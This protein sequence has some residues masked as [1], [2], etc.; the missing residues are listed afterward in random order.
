M[1]LQGDSKLVLK[2]IKSNSI[3][4]IATDPPYGIKFMGK[5]WDVDLPDIEIWEECYRV[6]KPG[7]FI[8][9]M[10]STRMDDLLSVDLRKSGF[11]KMDSIGWCYGCLSED[12]EILTDKGWVRYHKTIENDNVL[13]YN[14]NGDKYEWHKPTEKISY[15]HADTAYRIEGRYTDQLVSPDHR[16]AINKSGKVVF[17]EA[18]TCVWQTA[19]MVVLPRLWNFVFNTAS[20]VKTNKN[21]NLLQ[22]MQR[23]LSW[24]GTDKA[25]SQRACGL[26]RKIKSKLFKKND[27]QKQSSL[28]GWRNIF[29]EKRLLWRGQVNQVCKMPKRIYSDVAKR[30]VCN[31]ISVVSSDSSW[32]SFGKTGMRTS[33]RPQSSQQRVDKFNVI[34]NKQRP[35]TIRTSRR[36]ATDLARITPVYYKGL[37]W[38]IEVP[39]GAFVA[40]RNGKAFITGNSGFPKGTDLSKQLDK[41]TIRE[42]LDQH[43]HGLDA[44]QIRKVISAGINGE[45]FIPFVATE[46]RTSNTQVK[47]NY[48]GNVGCISDNSEG[49][50]LIAELEERFGEM[51]KRV[52]VGENPNKSGIGNA[53]N[54]HYTVGGTIA[55]T[56]NIT[57]PITPL[58][59]KYEG[60]KYGRQ[61]I[62]P[63]LEIILVFQKPVEDNNV[64][65]ILRFGT[66]G[67]NIDAG[68]IAGVKPL[69][70]VDKLRKN[71]SIFG[72]PSAMAKGNTSQGRYPANLM[73]DSVGASLLDK[74]SGV[75]K[76]TDN[77]RHNNQ[78]ITSGK[79]IYGKFNDKETTGY[80]DSGGSSRYFKQCNYS[81]LDLPP[82][83]YC[84]KPSKAEKNAGCE[85]N[86]QEV[87]VYSKGKA[88]R[89]PIHNKTN[90][91][92]LNTYSCGCPIVYTQERKNIKKQSNI[93]PTAKPT[94]LFRELIKLFKGTVDNPIILD[95]FAGSGT[96]GIAAIR[97]DCQYVLIEAEADYI[98]IIRARCEHW[99]A[100]PNQQNLF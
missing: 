88:G 30:R 29:Q 68:R 53:T 82:V 18:E 39:T 2:S 14:P 19:E 16:I 7:G 27:W 34:C 10:A 71:N 65:N 48:S 6:L 15:Q 78:S 38:C 1:I 44:S 79:G 47:D 36:T 66:G 21:T 23:L 59:Q 40:R 87:V 26:D 95:P 45:S 31:G 97:E 61:A 35:Q 75:T 50:A 11:D 91:S 89:C 69:R 56:V 60:V 13:C 67:V 76:S 80:N 22:K 8:L 64:D 3:D 96:T 25:F 62:K 43:E 99:E 77:I 55:E 57:A 46:N 90:P 84:A 70:I 49:V 81:E 72:S 32:A 83:I 73:I 41:R 5:R 86:M 58:S 85:G 12:T 42:W 37:M 52:K 4:L 28:E 51:P 93:H 63:A 20:V 54:G 33:Y 94:N 74:Q 98:P 17:V 100:I 9:A 24:L 92:G